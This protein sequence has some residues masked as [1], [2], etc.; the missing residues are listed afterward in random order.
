VNQFG[1]ESFLA[2]APNN[3][4]TKRQHDDII[5]HKTRQTGHRQRGYDEHQQ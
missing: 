2:E 5:R 1:D 3:G 4:S